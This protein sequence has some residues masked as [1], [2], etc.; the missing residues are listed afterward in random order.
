[1]AITAAPATAQNT[2]GRFTWK[3]E[4]RSVPVQDRL[5]VQLPATAGE[6]AGYAI[7]ARLGAPATAV[8]H[9]FS[10]AEIAPGVLA[11]R[12]VTEWPP[13]RLSISSGKIV[14]DDF[15]GR[16]AVLVVFLTL[17]GGVVLE[18]MQ[19][20]KRVA[21]LQPGP[22]GLYIRNGAVESRKIASL[23]ATLHAI[24]SDR[25]R[26]QRPAR[27]ILLPSGRYLVHEGDLKAHLAS[28]NTPAVAIADERCCATGIGI[29]IVIGEDGRVR[30]AAALR[31][32][33]EHPAEILHSCEQ[34]ARLWT[35]RPFV[36]SGKPH[37][38]EA[39]VLFLPDGKGKLVPALVAGG[40]D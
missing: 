18:V 29:R 28:L 40:N 37:A 36:F 32:S 21:Q 8:V 4:Y 38:V 1:L 25:S 16:D 14:I 10:I 35:F 6:R 22:G 24:T 34:A 11:P 7:G 27:P 23:S 20:E 26:A 19:G 31:G 9:A 13:A 39:A 2:Q 17:P 3:P 12:E 5:L 33:T 30:D 15:A